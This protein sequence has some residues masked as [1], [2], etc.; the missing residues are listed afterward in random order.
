MNELKK[1]RIHAVTIAAMFMTFG[2]GV[3]GAQAPSP[4]L[5]IGNAYGDA[6]GAQDRGAQFEGPGG[7]GGRMGGP[8]QFRGP[9]MGG[10]GM[11]GPGMG[12]PGQG[13]GGM[14]MRPKPGIVEIPAEG[15]AALLGLSADQ[16]AKIA[17]IQKTA[18]PPRP[19]GSVRTPDWEPRPEM[20]R[21]GR[22]NGG[23]AIWGTRSKGGSDGGPGDED[24]DAGPG[25]PAGDPR[26][27][28]KKAKADIMAVLTDVQKARLPQVMQ[29]LDALHA[30]RIPLEALSTLALTG[31][32]QKK[33]AD[34]GSEGHK[35]LVALLTADNDD[36]SA[37]SESPQD[38]HEG[39]GDDVNALL[40]SDQ[41]AKVR[42]ARRQ[43]RQEGG[44]GM[45]MPG[46][47]MGMD[48]GMM[49]PPG[50]MGMD[51]GRMGRGPM[52]GPQ[53]EPGMGFDGPPPPGDFGGGPG[54]GPGGPDGR[55][56]AG[57]G[58]RRGGAHRGG[59]PQGPGMDGGPAGMMAPG[60]DGGPSG[61]EGFGPPPPDDGDV[62]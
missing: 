31:D 8:G 22:P 2:A 1:N 44:P 21:P 6:W 59:R 32:Q 11:G 26:E 45:G 46:G 12:G 10:P 39:M 49:P 23:R 16:T 42:L 57:G 35:K 48:R 52:G 43:H 54:Q 34:I 37:T 5:A 47:G 9:G 62:L 17:A 60:A 55:F 41:R 15:L 38:I 13:P 7:P 51:G 61:P 20:G 29:E 4:H 19:A 3:A 14:A 18:R 30:A 50:V 56:G 58:P 27:A 33:I 25:R 28:R 36:D 40:T 53:G 24:A